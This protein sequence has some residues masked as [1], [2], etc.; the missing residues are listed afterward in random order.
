MME[1]GDYKKSRDLSWET[2]VK[3]NIRELP[4]QVLDLCQKMGIIVSSY[5]M[6]H[7]TIN[8]LGYDGVARVNDGFCTIIN[9]QYFIFYDETIQPHGRLKFTVAHELGHIM[10]GHLKSEN[11]AYRSKTTQWNRT[12]MDEPNSIESQANIFAS[13]LLAPACVLLELDID[14]VDDLQM[15][16]GLSHAAAKIRLERLKVLRDRSSFYVS[17]LERKAIEQFKDFINSE[18]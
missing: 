17:P 16:T 1:Y 14:N 15:L 6:G 7:K 10:L 2:I 9:N 3:Y 4:V 13:R 5:T 8:A 11:S 12:E 18:K